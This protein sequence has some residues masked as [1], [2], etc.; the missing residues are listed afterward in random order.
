MLI[1]IKLQSKQDVPMLDLVRAMCSVHDEKSGQ[2]LAFEYTLNTIMHFVLVVCSEV[3]N[4]A[5]IYGV[6][7]IMCIPGERG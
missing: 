7:Y 3:F 1:L 4:W 6:M 5:I 2:P